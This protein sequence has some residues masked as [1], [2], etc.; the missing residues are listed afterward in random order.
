MSES[1]TPPMADD[2]AVEITLQIPSRALREFTASLP[3]STLVEGL[4]HALKADKAM[5]EKV[6]VAVAL[7]GFDGPNDERLTKA[8]RKE[9]GIE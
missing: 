8:F 7:Y 1:Q 5:A 2:Q 3:A 6:A 9:L 4:V